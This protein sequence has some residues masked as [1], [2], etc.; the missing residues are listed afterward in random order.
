MM[1]PAL[2]G[3]GALLCL[4]VA[5]ALAASP[6][7]GAELLLPALFAPEPPDLC[8]CCCCPAFEASKNER[9]EWTWA[10]VGGCN[11]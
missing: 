2:P 8:P 10:C 3:F 7:N 11:P 4:G 9:R 6:R 1:R 5:K